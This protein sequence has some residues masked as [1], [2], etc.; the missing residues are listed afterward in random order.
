MQP[1][2][3][4][5]DQR[6]WSV[7][8]HIGGVFVSFIVPLVILLVFKGRGAFVEDQAKE[9]LNFQITL[10][11]AYFVGGILTIVLIGI[12][13]LLAAAVCS[14]VFAIMAAIASNRGELYRYPLTLRLVK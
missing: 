13:I 4:D 11:I 7:F 8:A 5:S 3:T 6:M 2:L 12:L 10:A 9:A 14:V 1:P